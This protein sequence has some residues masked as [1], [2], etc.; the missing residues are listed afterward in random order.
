MKG[1][2]TSDD[3]NGARSRLVPVSNIAQTA[4]RHL[5]IM[6]LQLKRS[7]T[8]CSQNPK[9]S[10]VWIKQGWHVTG[11]LD[12]LLLYLTSGSGMATVISYEIERQSVE[13]VK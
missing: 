12:P 3:E 4:M 9:N 1:P 10:I 11:C 2:F 8:I 7:R 5:S 6:P 13:G